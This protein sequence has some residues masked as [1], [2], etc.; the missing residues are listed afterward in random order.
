MQKPYKDVFYLSYTGITLAKK[1][2]NA[3][4][5][6]QDSSNKNKQLQTNSSNNLQKELSISDCFESTSQYTKLYK[7]NKS[8][9]RKRAIAFSRLNKSKQHFYFYTITFPEKL[10][11]NQC[12]D[13]LNI[14]LTRLRKENQINDY[15][16]IT[17]RQKNST[18]HFHLL[19]ND[20]INVRTWNNYIKS[21]LVYK[22]NR[23]EFDYERSKI[24][25]YNGV[26]IAKNRTSRK[27][28]NFA[29]QKDKRLI[30]SYLTK[31]IT[32][33]NEQ[34]SR[35]PFH[36]SHSIANLIGNREIT[37]YEASYIFSEFDSS[38]NNPKTII[39]DWFCWYGFS[40][41]LDNKAFEF[42][43]LENERIYNKEEL[44]IDSSLVW[45]APQ[46]VVIVKESDLFS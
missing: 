39:S 22:L 1:W 11:D 16:W 32:K 36:S 17:E 38:N 35:L 25:N 30:I 34:F 28:I 26:D 37:D 12:F 23:K 4:K 31:Y 40:N 44:T 24:E 18:L 27:V 8:K 46:K 41:N 7:L 3:K 19:T 20:V 45:F 5:R 33:N 10:P 43:D 42:L 6:N 14:S 13:C 15:L 21:S 2:N 9:V 29:K